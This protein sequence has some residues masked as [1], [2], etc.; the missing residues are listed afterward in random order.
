M[1]RLLPYLKLTIV[2][3]VLVV[4]IQAQVRNKHKLSRQKTNQAQQG[5][6]KAASEKYV[7][8]D[9]YDPARNAEQDIRM[10]VAEAGREGKRILL[11]V[12]GEWCIWCHTMD[13]FFEKNPELLALREKNF[14]MVK[15]NF[16]DENK[17]ELL[18]S[19][20]P[21]ING[22]PHLFVLERDGKFLHSQDTGKLEEGKSYNLAKFMAFLKEWSP[23][24]SKSASK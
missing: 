16:S 9:K 12:G 15:I 17:N 6:Q 10:A 21:P 23:P 5:K 22:Y 13:A 14:I 1:K 20:Y 19:R 11:E 2:C 8:V 18:L 24:E 3:L 7:P 4:G